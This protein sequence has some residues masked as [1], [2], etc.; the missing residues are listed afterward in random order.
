VASGASPGC[1]AASPQALACPASLQAAKFTACGELDAGA[2]TPGA[3]FCTYASPCAS[4]P[5]YVMCQCVQAMQA[6]GEV[7]FRYQCPDLCAPTDDGGS[8]PPGAL[9][10]AT[11]PEAE[12][13]AP[14]SDGSV[15]DS[16]A[17]PRPDSAA[18]AS[19]PDAYGD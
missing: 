17:L 19:P 1:P 11:Y 4:I 6:S 8:S 10:D 12:T 14:S 18:D 3:L 16:A 13:G 5:A 9:P 7:Y 2:P 15:H